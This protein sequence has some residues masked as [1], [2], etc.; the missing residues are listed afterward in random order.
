MSAYDLVKDFIHLRPCNSDELKKLSF[1]CDEHYKRGC[2]KDDILY[3]VDSKGQYY[4]AKLPIIYKGFEIPDKAGRLKFVSNQSKNVIENNMRGLHIYS[5]KEQNDFLL[6]VANKRSKYKFMEHQSTGDT[7]K[8]EKRIYTGVKGEF[9]LSLFTGESFGDFND[10]SASSIKHECPDCLSLN[11]GVKTAQSSFGSF[12]V[13]GESLW[14]KESWPEIFVT[15]MPDNPFGGFHEIVH[16]LV[17]LSVLHNKQYL[18]YSTLIVESLLNKAI[19]Y[20]TKIGINVPLEEYIKCYSTND[21]NCNSYLKKEFKSKNF[22]FSPDFHFKLFFDNRYL[23]VKSKLNNIFYL[24]RVENK[25]FVSSIAYIPI[26]ELGFLNFSDF[27]VYA[28]KYDT[29]YFDNF[30]I[31]DIQKS[32]EIYKL[33]VYFALAYNMGVVFYSPLEYKENIDLSKYYNI[34]DDENVFYFVDGEDVYSQMQGED[35]I[36]RFCDK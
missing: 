18:T 35:C 20:N 15:D 31:M 23:N 13:G 12:V 30:K 5:T 32:V 29:H 10:F 14:E 8:E 9:A 19:V 17:P 25:G 27:S 26:T 1:F 16:G 7:E 22:V 4:C 11:V 33:I 2:L 34:Y 3:V 21:L 36:R 28:S 24:N 6:M